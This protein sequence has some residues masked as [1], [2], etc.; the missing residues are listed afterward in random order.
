MERWE[1]E[2][3]GGREVVKEKRRGRGGG[4][5]GGGGG[6]GKRSTCTCT[7]VVAGRMTMWHTFLKNREYGNG[8]A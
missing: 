8:L 3:E 6:R 2:T 4:G 5:G 1:G 7:H